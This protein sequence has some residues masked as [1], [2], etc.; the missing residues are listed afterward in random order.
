MRK[1]LSLLITCLF[2]SVGMAMAQTKIT[3]SVVDDKGEPIIGASITVDGGG[4]V[5][6]VTDVDGNFS[7]SVPA[8]KKIIVSYLGMQQQTLTPKS[9]MQIT[10]H[11]DNQTLNEVVVTGMSNMDRRMFTGATDQIKASDAMLGGMGDISRSLEGRAA[12]VSVQNVSGTFGTAP[13]IRVRG[14]TSIYGSSKPLWVVDGVVQEDISDIS[15][16]D[17]S[18]G[19]AET[20]ISS[21]IAGLN[22]D[23]IESFQILK[24]GSATSIYGARAMAGVI[25]VTTKKGRQGQAHLSYTGEFTTRMIPSYSQFNILNSQEQMGI[26]KEMA[27]KGW[28]NFSDVLNGADY[29]VYGDMYKRITTFDA[30]TGQF[31][32][33]NTTEAKNGFLQQAEWRNTNWFKEL[34]Q[35]SIMQN[36]SLSLSGGTAKSNYYISMSLM[37]DPGWYKESN[38]KRYTINVNGSHNIL[39]NLKLTLLGSASYRKQKAPG[40]LNQNVDVVSGQVKRDFDINP[41]SYALKTSRALDPNTFYQT[42]Y[43]PFNILYEL[44]NNNID[45]NVLNTKFQGELTYNPIKDLRL[46]V[47][48]AV[49]YDKSS[50]ENNISENSNQAQAY[51]A[52]PNA[53]IR[54]ANQYLYTDPE[55]AYSLPISVLPNGGFYQR[56]DLSKLSWDVRGTADYHHTFKSG[57]FFDV[58]GGF[59]VSDVRR[60]RTWFNGV[61]MQFTRGEIPFF[62][63]QYFKQ[64]QEQNTTYYTLTHTK[65]RTA[66]FFATATYSYKQ[67]Y[68]LTGTYRYEGTNR[69]GRARSARWLPTW[70]ISGSWNADQETWFAPT[71][72]NV[73]THAMMRLSYSLTGDPGPAD[74]TNSTVILQSY[75]PYR[76]FSSDRE[77]GIQIAQIANADLTYEKKHEFNLGFEFGFLNNR[78]NTTMDFFWRNNYDLIGPIATEG[79]GGEVIRYANMASMKSSGQEFSLETRNIMKKNFSW[80]TNFIFSHVTT[81]VTKLRARSRTIDLISGNGFAMEGHPYRGLYSIPYAGLN[82]K[83]QPQ[84][85][86]PDGDITTYDINFQNRDNNQYLIYEG[87]TD[88]TIT[89]SLGNVFKYKGFTLNLFVTYSFGNVIR[90]DPVFRAR[91]NDLTSMTKEYRNRWMESGDEAYT[92]VPAILSYRDYSENKQLRYGYNAYNYTHDR[93]AKGDFI[94]MKDISLSYDFPKKWFAG[95]P[96]SNISLKL[97]A[98]NLFLFYADKKLQ[99]QDPEFINAGGVAAPLPRQYTLTVKLGM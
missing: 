34:F 97:Q 33:A 31:E 29:G 80:T 19:D 74:Y 62:I 66:A 3:G 45:M 84:F 85:Y 67:R 44:E 13:K 69:L 68:N 48:G 14:A 47:I 8:G 64:L 78:I 87:P 5:G 55:E 61:G 59:D 79:V 18:S 39:D 9:K 35:T 83:G 95:T 99:G 17:L 41:Y 60:E 50:Q 91:Y 22:S 24:D 23:D 32:L 20:L 89:G 4:K 26:Y 6:T 77:T 93:I 65:S 36:H 28:L 12:G 43:A 46:D 10:L 76:I 92:S 2:L 25:V 11:A 53:I 72:K 54:D 58:L 57:H 49:Q 52:M 30:T 27:D 73:L 96:F 90:L 42:N 98:T 37:S 16:D 75:T 15:A 70:N 51:R 56:T 86:T 7:I 63:S 81:D 21:A 82:E 71:F 88:P 94:R 40:T 1:R 38:V